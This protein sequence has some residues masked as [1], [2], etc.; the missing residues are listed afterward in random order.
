MP[1]TGAN[2]GVW[3]RRYTVVALSFLAV[4][5]CYIDRVNISVAIIPM[6]ADLGW[7]PEMQGRVLASFFVGY[8]LLQVAGGRLADRFG[9]K[10]V[11]GAGVLAWSL[12]TVLTPPAAYLGFGVLIAV[13]ILM[14]TGEAVTFPSIYTIYSRWV[15]L[16]ERSRAVALANSGIPLGT[17]FAL[18]VTPWIVQ[19]F[20]WEW[21]F[22][23]FGAVGGLW[24]IAWYL[25]VTSKPADHPRI[26]AQELAE[27]TDGITPQ[28][29]AVSVPWKAL[30]KSMP[31]WAI[32]VAHFCNNWSL[33]VLLSWLPTFVNQGLGVDYAAVG[34][35]TMIPHIASFIFLNVAGNIAD[36]LIASGMDVGRVRKLMQSIG[37]GGIAIA[38]LIVGQVETAWMAI[39]VM[40]IGNALAAFVTGGFAVNHMDIAP[41]HAGTLMGI[42]NT[43][44]TIPGIIGV[45]VTGLILDLTGSWALVFQVAAGVTIVGLVFFLLFS[46][47]RKLFD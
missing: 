40:T 35:V 1:A 23:L 7:T 3:P 47:G 28:N 10:V 2:P 46:S 37:A 14:G 30:F 15:P 42:T 31:V 22:Y 11:L 19:A 8:L 9:G 34:W 32:I 43:A 41:R 26:D 4:F 25:Q 45:Y 21:A 6:A 16:T 13:R 24:W 27:I 5:V 18:V 44:G 12:F 36:R 33:Y 39:T 17:V 20:G 29:E 38:L